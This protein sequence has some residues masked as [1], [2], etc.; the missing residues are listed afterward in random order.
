MT[1]HAFTDWAGDMLA[2]IQGILVQETKSMFPEEQ[3]NT[4]SYGGSYF[5]N[6]QCLFVLPSSAET[7]FS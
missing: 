2:C 1:N 3:P 5:P 6:S 4:D 7:L